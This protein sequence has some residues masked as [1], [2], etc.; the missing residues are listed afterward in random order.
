MFAE[1]KDNPLMPGRMWWNANLRN[2]CLAC[3]LFA[4]PK[5]KTLIILKL[6][7]VINWTENVFVSENNIKYVRA[8]R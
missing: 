6:F 4:L 5:Q 7:N 2:G 3:L 1:L 8:V